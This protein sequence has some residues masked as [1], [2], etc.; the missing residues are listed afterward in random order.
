[1]E[2]ETWKDV[3][4]YNGLYEVS[5]LGRIKSLD[6]VVNNK[7]N[8]KRTMKGRIM[9]LRPDSKGRYIICDFKSRTESKTKLVHRV[10]ANAF[11]GDIQGMEINHIDGNTKNNNVSNLEICTR[12]ENEIHKYRV[13]K[14]IHPS[15]KSVA[16]INIQTGRIDKI[17]S[18]MNKV[19][20]DGFIFTS[21]SK[22]CLG[23]QIKHKGFKWKHYEI[24]S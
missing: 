5:N 21:V 1:M 20:I 6:R 24:P 14:R 2:K 9:S 23:K 16:R 18:P 19:E 22:C 13:L 17:Y 8:S 3:I 12:H 15:V 10:V 7:H 11:I 4:G